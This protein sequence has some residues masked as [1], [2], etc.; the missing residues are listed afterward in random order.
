[1]QREEMQQLVNAVAQL[2]TL[3]MAGI[4]MGGMFR[5]L[6]GALSPAGLTYLP[7]VES[8]KSEHA[9]VSLVS[10]YDLETGELKRIESPTGKPL[11]VMEKGELVLTDLGKHQGYEVLGGLY[12]RKRHG[13]E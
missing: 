12:L 9:L 3:G 10:V 4:V 5:G 7:K 8:P 2:M 6:A 11:A 1:M 13:R